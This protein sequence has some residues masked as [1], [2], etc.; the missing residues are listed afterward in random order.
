MQV[1]APTMTK[2]IRPPMRRLTL[3]VE[4]PEMPADRWA[5]VEEIFHAVCE[6]PADRRE[7][8]LHDRCGKDHELLEEVRSLLEAQRH[9]PA[10]MNWS[11]P[12]EVTRREADAAI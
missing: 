7:S 8:L 1:I 5:Q 12:E 10:F 3:A 6:A 4:I 11:V 9:D 2:A